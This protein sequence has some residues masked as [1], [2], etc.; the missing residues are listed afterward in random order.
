MSGLILPPGH[1][2]TPPPPPEPFDPYPDE[3]AKIQAVGK[4]LNGMFAYTGEESDT[5]RRFEMTARS[6]FGEIGFDI[7][8]EWMQAMDPET[9]EELP[10]KAP[11]LSIIGRTKKEQ[12]TDHERI[13]WGVVKGMADGQA[14]YVRED[15]SKREDPIK[16]IIT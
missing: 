14:G 12:E 5:E 3:Y 6:L 11:H 2:R 8:I 9:G 15:G 1:K 16:R 4:R 7:A 13:Q 10:F